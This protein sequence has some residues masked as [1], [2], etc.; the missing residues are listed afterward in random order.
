MLT[1]VVLR[2]EIVL[3]RDTANH[4]RACPP[5][6]ASIEHQHSYVLVN[7]LGVLLAHGSR[8]AIACIS[9]YGLRLGCADYC[10]R[11]SHDRLVPHSTPEV[12]S[13]PSRS[14]HRAAW[15]EAA[16]RAEVTY[17]EDFYHIRHG[18]VSHTRVLSHTR[19]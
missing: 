12:D 6:D 15:R 13:T 11:P 4:G 8:G 16:P 2:I 17:S 18:D 9:G 5:G 19:V 14:V 3:S 7:A 10:K 1:S